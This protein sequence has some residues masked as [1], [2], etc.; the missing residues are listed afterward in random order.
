MSHGRDAIWP[1]IARELT[2]AAPPEAVTMAEE[3]RRRFGPGVAAVLFHGSCLRDRTVEDRILD[4]YALVD[5]YRAIHRNLAARAANA[6]LPPNVYYLEAGHEGGRAIRA[7]C[8][9]ISLRAFEQRMRPRAFHSYFWARFAQ[10][11]ALVWAR[12]EACHQRIALALADAVSTLIGEARPLFAQRPAP[13]AL[14][15]EALARAYR[16]ELRSER[17]DRAAEI[18]AADAQRYDRLT[19]LVLA[20]DVPPS[21]GR[22]RRARMRWWGRRLVGKPL[23]VARL[24]KAAF[25]FA[26]GA[27]YLIWKMSRHS[28]LRID[29][30]PW[31]RRHPILA[32]TVLFWRLYRQGAFR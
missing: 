17:G 26:G 15:I 24:I 22:R 6:V 14:W 20:E 11:C 5:D 25:T 19:P 12:D 23:S 16:A 30:S 31:Q 4:L 32:S 13:D 2:V 21:P 29:L 28:G 8:A 18:Y 1:I 9:V 7:K 10:P 27:D 3:V